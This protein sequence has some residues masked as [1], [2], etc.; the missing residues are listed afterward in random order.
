MVIPSNLNRE[1][2]LIRL[3][4][5]FCNNHLHQISQ[6]LR[7][8]FRLKT[9]N[10]ENISDFLALRGTGWRDVHFANVTAETPL[11]SKRL[12]IRSLRPLSPPEIEAF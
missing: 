1:T 4:S 5:V 3:G 9:D 12:V 11:P 10:Y 7:T 6:D 2:R 8:L